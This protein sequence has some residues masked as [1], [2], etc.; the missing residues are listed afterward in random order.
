[1]H[2]FGALSKTKN[3][4]NLSSVGTKTLSVRIP[5][6]DYINILQSA[7]D[8]KLTTSE[9]IQYKLLK[10]DTELQAVKNELTEAKKSVIELK[11]ALSQKPKEV[12]VEKIVPKE[13]IKEV[14]VEKIVPK[15]VI[16]EV[17]KTVENT[18]KINQL[19]IEKN[20][21]VTRLNACNLQHKKNADESLFISLKQ[22]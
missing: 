6:S 7:M 14:I 5:T 12:I 13:V 20:D 1:M 15:E 4:S 9:F 10:Q 21:M 17:V 3:M 8:N 19:I 22:F 18:D 16:K 11:T 2:I